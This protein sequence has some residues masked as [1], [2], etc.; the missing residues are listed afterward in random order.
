MVVYFTSS[1]PTKHFLTT[2]GR[3]WI[4]ITDFSVQSYYFSFLDDD[5][6]DAVTHGADQMRD[7]RKQLFVFESAA[8]VA[9]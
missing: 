6:G 3:P 5:D 1:I 4:F 8:A 2:Y 9:G 7:R